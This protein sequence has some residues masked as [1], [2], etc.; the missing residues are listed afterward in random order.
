MKPSGKDKVV[1]IFA[2]DNEWSTTSVWW[3]F[4]Y[5]LGKTASCISKISLELRLPVTISL[6]AAANENEMNIFFRLY[7]SW[8]RQMP[9]DWHEEEKKKETDENAR[10]KSPRGITKAWSFELLASALIFLRVFP[11]LSRPRPTA[12]MKMK[13][14]FSSIFLHW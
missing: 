7:S 2:D 10:V 1:L 5:S 3:T 8:Q 6:N 9:S 11:S 14:F 13:M 12:M 4:F